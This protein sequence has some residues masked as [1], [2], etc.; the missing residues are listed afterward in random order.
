[1]KKKIL[2]LLIV[3]FLV[4]ACLNSIGLTMATS[5]VIDGDLSDWSGVTPILNDPVGDPSPYGWDITSAYIAQDGV[6]LYFR[7]DHAQPVPS[8]VL[9][10]NIT[11]RTSDGNVYLICGC[12]WAVYLAKVTPLIEDWQQAESSTLPTTGQE[13]RSALSADQTS[14]EFYVPL[15][16]IGTPTYVDLVFMT[17]SPRLGC[18]RAPDVGYVT[19]E[20]SI[21]SEDIDADGIL[22]DVDIQPLIFS[23]SFSDINNGGS[24]WGTIITR[25]DQ[26]LTIRD[27]PATTEDFGLRITADPS[28]GIIPANISIC[29]TSFI[30]LGPGDEIIV[31]HGSI[32]IKV[33]SGVVDA[34]FVATDGTIAT[35]ELNEGT[36][37]VFE[38]TSTTFIN[39]GEIEA[40]VKIDNVE[41]SIP[42][43]NEWFTP[44]LKLEPNTLNLKS[45]GNYITAFI[46]LPSSH[47][48]NEVEISSIMLQVA[49]YSY[50]VDLSAA[51]NIGDY[52]GN[53]ISDLMIKFQRQTVV[54]NLKI[55]DY[56]AILGKSV[57]VN[58]VVSGSLTDG[59]S[60]GCSDTLSILKK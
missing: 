6:N 21:T 33:V 27:E 17:N 42:T 54:N 50:S 23:N 39:I 48:I 38:P 29:D 9:V 11:L 20:I 49:G 25:G 26:I 13:G 16:D 57:D 44:S 34:S 35:S 22:N 18:D 14:L 12:P 3:L 4:V 1:L 53:G 43:G 10:S 2:A 15:A 51:I 40:T 60:F 47:D 37:I 5:I 19:Y 52:N 31:T 45:N 8:G 7:I 36:E 56:S 30:V 32:K 59:T 41:Y 58:F 24:T 28:G 46:E 55:M